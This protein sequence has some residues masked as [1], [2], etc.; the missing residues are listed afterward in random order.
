MHHRSK[1]K[2]DSK[3]GEEQ[4]SEPVTI[5]VE[6]DKAWKEHP[7]ML[8]MIKTKE[9]TPLGLGVRNPFSRR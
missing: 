8:Q 7:E 9:T 4:K 6:E 1:R 3:P 2:K 5:Y